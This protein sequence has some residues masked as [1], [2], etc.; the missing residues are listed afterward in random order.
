VASKHNIFIEQGST[1]H[2]YLT[3]KDPDGTPIDLTGYRIRMQARQEPESAVKLL[4][5]DSDALGAG[6]SI[7]ALDATGAINITLAPSATSP[8]EF[9][10][11]DW[12]LLAISSGGEATRL[13]EGKASVSLAVTR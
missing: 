12:D 7:A 11:A 3:W 1:F 9:R 5:F 13:L 8:L 6:Q 4:D 10:G 2:L